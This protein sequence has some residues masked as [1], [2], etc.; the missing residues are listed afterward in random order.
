MKALLFF[1]AL[2]LGMTAKANK[3]LSNDTIVVEHP[4]KV[5]I[6][7]SDSLQ[8][9]LIEG[10]QKNPNYRYESRLELVDSNYV[11]TSSMNADTWEL[12]FN[13]FKKKESKTKNQ[14]SGWFA[15]GFSDALG[16]PENVDI[17]PFKSWELWVVLADAEI[18]PWNNHHAFSAGIGLDWRN[19]RMVDDYRFIAKD[20]QIVVDKYPDGVHPKFSRI[21]V[22]SLNVPL[23]YQYQGKKFGFSVG[24]VVNFN[25]YSSVKT[26]YALDGKDIKEIHKNA[27]V[28][29]ITIDFMG[30]LH[31]AGF[32][33][34]FKYSPC[35]MLKSD[36][37]PKFQTLS[38]GFIL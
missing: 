34:Y 9:I 1:M 37:A 19:F 13:P 21:K 7:N 27:K 29:P 20:N 4:D 16:T 24:P 14:V 11:S 22:F 15:F 30:T 6:I 32:D 23:R 36:Y 38:F 2:S 33:L 17:K 5:T 12:S 3:T 25:T 10:A 18:H 8:S 28:N 35:N 31:V 26:R